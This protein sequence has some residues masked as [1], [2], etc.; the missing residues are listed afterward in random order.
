MGKRKR[1]LTIRHFLLA[2]FVSR[3]KSSPFAALAAY[4]AYF[5]F[6]KERQ[7]GRGNAYAGDGYAAGFSTSGRRIYP[8]CPP[9]YPQSL[10]FWAV[11]AVHNSSAPV[12]MPRKK[13]HNPAYAVFCPE[14]GQVARRCG[15]PGRTMRAP[16]RVA[17]LS[18]GERQRPP[19]ESAAPPAAPPA[20]ALPRARRVACRAARRGSP[21]RPPGC[22]PCHSPR[23]APPPRRALPPRP[24]A[25]PAARSLP[26]SPP[27]CSPPRP[28]PPPAAPRGEKALRPP[29][30]PQKDITPPGET[31]C[32]GRGRAPGDALRPKRHNAARGDGVTRDR[33]EGH[34]G[35][36]AGPAREA[37]P[38]AGRQTDGCQ[39]AFSRLCSSM[40]SLSATRAINSPLVGLSFLP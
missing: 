19:K 16:A 4:F 26:R 15:R 5:S 20:G 22:L 11:A 40:S 6:W 3:K 33:D 29:G 18:H 10:A 21:P 13:L 32:A 28:A 30:S 12:D 2:T 31:H 8:H 35:P 36:V 1:S 34:A 17:W 25:P 23:P 38:G 24:A 27:L 14:W 37:P 9:R 7:R 39:T